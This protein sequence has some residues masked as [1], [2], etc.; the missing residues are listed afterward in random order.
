MVLKDFFPP[1]IRVEKEARSLVSEGYRIY[2]L[3]WRRRE[4]KETETVKEI[5]VYRFK[6]PNP[7]KEKISLFKSLSTANYNSWRKPMERFVERFKINALHIH[8]LPLVGPGLRVAR[9]K[10][11][12]LVA[13]LHENYPYAVQVWMKEKVI[14]SILRVFIKLPLWLDY[15]Q[16]CS[17]GADR[18]IVTTP[19]AKER[20]KLHGV[21]EEKII[22]LENTVDL[23][24]G[25]KSA[26]F[27]LRKNYEN[28]FIILYVDGLHPYKG[29]LTIIKAM[30]VLRKKAKDIKL[31]LVGERKRREEKSLKKLVK[32]LNLEKEV[33]FVKWSPLER[34]R[35]Y[36][37]VSDVCLVP[38]ERNPQSEA[39]SPH[40]LFQY[41]LLGK[42]VIVSD[43]RSLKRVV[44]DA[45]CGLIFRAGDEKDLV[46]KILTLYQDK[47][48]REILGKN[49]E[50]A[51]KEKYNWQKESQKLLSLYKELFSGR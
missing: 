34:L 48:L 2:L 51:V 40:K 23:G 17:L 46:E 5:D 4:E 18:V 22:V 12:P 11:I 47:A 25:K 43:C 10:G 38:F 29:S 28:D 6:K 13:D 14:T 21:E 27:S 19:E 8:D 20:I 31:L 50:K 35:N 7:I 3:C 44:E 24:F 32:R 26:S 39:S 16:R 15:E 37:L 33:E 36:I 9:K 42:P 1:D 49:G 30:G 41:M 45:K